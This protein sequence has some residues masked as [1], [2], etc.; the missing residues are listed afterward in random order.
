MFGST[1]LNIGEIQSTG[2][3]IAV[4]FA[5]V[6][7]GDFT[8]NTGI[9]WTSYL[10][11][12]LVSL[13]DS[14]AGFD[15]GGFRD[16]SNLGAPGQN[17]TPLIRVEEGADIGQIWGLVFEGISGDGSWQFAD[18]NGDGTAAGDNNDRAVIGSGLPTGQLGW[19]NSF[20][21]GNFDANFFLRGTFGHDL[22][23]T[24]R[25]FYE[26]PNQIGSYNILSSSDPNLT[27][28]PT[29]SSFHVESGNFLRLDNASIGYTCLLYTSPS[30]RDATLSRM[31]SSA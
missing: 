28:S 17:N 6:Q 4:D 21:F 5:A 14:E 1:Q 31:P 19:N 12:E 15:F 7:S 27:D 20:T 3:E 16:I 22:V 2:L 25:A 29:F 18:V 26:A 10:K 11:N 9:S 30:P 23:N 13:S 24:F 8:W